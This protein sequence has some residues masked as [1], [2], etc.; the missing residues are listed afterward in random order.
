MFIGLLGTVNI[1]Y[2]HNII[3]NKNVIWQEHEGR[4]EDGAILEQSFCMPLKLS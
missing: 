3:Y 4:V 1:R 2:M